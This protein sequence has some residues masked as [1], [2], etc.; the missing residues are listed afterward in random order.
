MAGTGSV[1]PTNPGAKS[2]GK[3]KSGKK[4]SD[5]K[6]SG[7]RKSGGRRRSSARSIMGYFKGETARQIGSVAEIGLAT[8]VASAFAGYRFGRSSKNMMVLASSKP[9]GFKGFDGRA[10]ISLGGIALGLWK[11]QRVYGPHILRIA[12]GIGL[13]YVAEASNDYT[14]RMGVKALNDDNAKKGLAPV[15]TPVVALPATTPA[16]PGATAQGVAMIDQSGRFMIGS[17]DTAGS[18]WES[19]LQRAEQAT[20]HAN[21]LR[22]K[23]GMPALTPTQA[24]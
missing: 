14:Y 24:Y 21:E 17:T 6:K 22:V 3:P 16:A 19:P 5:S 23:A 11:R 9:D 8:A 10:L 12:T 2:G 7:T 4:R 20:R 18:F 13:S 15:S 1:M